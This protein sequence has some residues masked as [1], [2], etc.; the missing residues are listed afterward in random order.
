[1]RVLVPRSFSFISLNQWSDSKGAGAIWLQQGFGG[2]CCINSHLPRPEFLDS[3][4]YQSIWLKIGIDSENTS[5]NMGN[6]ST[7][8]DA[9]EICGY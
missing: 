9:D 8:L 5:T 6:H 4:R 7:T 1:M 3:R 2:R